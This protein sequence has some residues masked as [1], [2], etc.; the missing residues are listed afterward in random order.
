M[1]KVRANAGTRWAGRSAAASGDYAEGVR[2]PRTS[3]QAATLAAE[4]AQAAGVQK[5][6]AEKRY[7]KGVSRAGDSKWQAKTLEKGPGRFSEGVAGAKG[8]Y[9]QAVAPYTSVLESLSLPPRQAVGSDANYARVMAVGK[10]LH[11]KKM[12]K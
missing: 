3:W 6:I 10:A 11:A 8:D 12:G 9:E 1:P 7:A 4:G 2:N 5:A